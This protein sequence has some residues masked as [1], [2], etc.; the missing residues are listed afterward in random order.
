[1]KSKFIIA[2]IALV[3]SV[4][5][6]QSQNPGFIALI[7]NAGS[8]S[9]GPGPLGSYRVAPPMVYVLVIDQTGSDIYTAT[10]NYTT[11]DGR[12]GSKTI[13]QAASYPPVQGVEP[14]SNCTLISFPID[15]QTIAPSST[16]FA[17]KNTGVMA[18][19]K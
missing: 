2:A 9:P 19:L 8:S 18:V 14:G 11:A 12:T 1:M 4:V 3:A 13:I 16:V 5:S 6:A 15:A 10:I 7:T 17:A